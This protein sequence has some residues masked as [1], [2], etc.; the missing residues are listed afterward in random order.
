ML[1]DSK[2]EGSMF[3]GDLILGSHGL[4]C[5]HGASFGTLF[6]AFLSEATVLVLSSEL[7][8]CVGRFL[9]VSVQLISC[10][11]MFV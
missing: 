9:F 6:L 7:G 2:M 3:T 11:D 5:L 1:L 8:P 10:F 4:V